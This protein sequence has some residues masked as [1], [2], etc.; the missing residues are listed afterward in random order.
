MG[1]SSRSTAARLRKIAEQVQLRFKD[2]KHVN[3]KTLRGRP[4]FRESADHVHFMDSKYSPERLFEEIQEAAEHGDFK[5]IVRFDG[6][7]T[8]PLVE[9]VGDCQMHNLATAALLASALRRR[10]FDVE[11]RLWESEVRRAKKGEDG[12]FVMEHTV[13][14]RIRW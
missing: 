4:E 11:L 14:L 10:F 12:S 2:A 6:S 7:D 5:L 9:D 8:M 13:F 3:E 1:G